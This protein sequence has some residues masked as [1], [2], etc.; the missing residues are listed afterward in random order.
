MHGGEAADEKPCTGAEDMVFGLEP[1]DEAGVIALGDFA[2]ADEGVHFVDIAPD[3]LGEAAGAVHLRVGRVTQ[4]MRCFHNPQKQ[5]VEKR[6]A[7]RVAVQE[8]GAGKAEEVPGNG[9]GARGFG[10]QFGSGEQVFGLAAGLPDD[11]MRRGAA[12]DERAGGGAPAFEVVFSGE[13][14]D[15]HR[16]VCEKV[17]LHRGWFQHGTE[18]LTV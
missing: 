17:S 12:E 4:D 11:I 7:L 8:G 13:T 16:S 15:G 18:I 9:E 3:G 14:D 5:T 10:W 1:G 6:K 2:E